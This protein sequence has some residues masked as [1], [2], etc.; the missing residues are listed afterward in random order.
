MKAEITQFGSLMIIPENQVEGMGI[1]KWFDE[2]VICNQAEILFIIK[3]LDKIL[4]EDKTFRAACTRIGR[5]GL[6][7]ESD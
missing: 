6:P 5:I 3:P 2:H 4:E 7:N 1:E